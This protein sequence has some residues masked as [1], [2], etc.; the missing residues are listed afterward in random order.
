MLRINPKNIS[1][2]QFSFV[3]ALSQNDIY[4]SPIYQS[5]EMTRLSLVGVGAGGGG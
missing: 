2:S 1:F 3:K 5:N 4:L